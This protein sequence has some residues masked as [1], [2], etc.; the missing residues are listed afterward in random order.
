[1]LVLG[2]IRGCR[3]PPII[4]GLPV[5]DEAVEVKTPSDYPLPP[6]PVCL[7]CL[8]VKRLDRR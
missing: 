2:R 3:L 1:M 6:S 5:S 8:F 7:F 4:D